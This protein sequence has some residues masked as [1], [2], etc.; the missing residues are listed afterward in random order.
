MRAGPEVT[1]SPPKCISSGV[2]RQEIEVGRGQRSPYPPPCWPWAGSLMLLCFRQLQP[3]LGV[4]ASFSMIVGSHTGEI[5]GAVFTM[6]PF[7]SWEP[8]RGAASPP[9]GSWQVS[10]HFVDAFLCCAKAF[11]FNYVPFLYFCFYFH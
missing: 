10:F 7:I 9:F 6:G 2:W 1:P 11:M 3:S 5:L 8:A 4:F